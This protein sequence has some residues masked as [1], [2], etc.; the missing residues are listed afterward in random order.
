[1]V[2]YCWCLI[3][4]R[5]IWGDYIVFSYKCVLVMGRS[6]TLLAKRLAKVA[7]VLFIQIHILCN[8]LLIFN[9]YLFLFSTLAA[10][11]QLERHITVIMS[12]FM[13]GS[14]LSHKSQT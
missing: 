13:V 6:I 1:M 5:E 12:E 14:K 8:I 11:L 7:L 4:V 10:F 2:G 9:P 3:D